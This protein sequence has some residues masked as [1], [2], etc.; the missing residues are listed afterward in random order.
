M[1]RGD[2][3]G[4]R[5][6]PAPGAR[7]VAALRGNRR[8]ALDHAAQKPG[9]PD[10]LAASL[11]A[12]PVHA[13]VPV[14]GAHQRQAVRAQRQAAVDGA[15]AVLVHAGGLLAGLGCVIRV[16]SAFGNRRSVDECHVL[17]QHA[18]VARGLQVV[19]AG[20]GQPQQ[21]VRKMG[22]HAFAAGRVPP[23]LHVTFGKLARSTEH[24]LGAQ[25]RRVGQRQRHRV[26]QLVAKA[27]SAASLIEAG[28]GPKAADHGLVEQ[29]VVDQGI[30]MGIGR[31]DLHLAEQA[32]PGGL[33]TGQRLAAGLLR[34]PG[35]HLIG[36]GGI[37]GMAE[38]EAEGQF[39]VA[40]QRKFAGQTGTG[41]AT[42][43]ALAS[44][45]VGQEQPAQ[46]V[47]KL[48]PVAGPLQ[49]A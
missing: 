40:G 42:G 23:V 27:R 25:P 2:P 21:V 14:A 48:A 33:D 46:R 44:Q 30:E 17:V 49:A 45:D 4:A 6:L 34:P 10:R 3:A 12:D 35:G 11:M 38:D 37:D 19:A 28:L 8:K 26:L 9:Q 13:V 16:F 39:F 1:Q 20:V 41:V 31:A 22:A 43:A 36:F 18:G 5:L 24:D 7:I 32:R 47:K 29:P 15:G